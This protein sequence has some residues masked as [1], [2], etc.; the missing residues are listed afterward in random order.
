MISQNGVPLMTGAG[1]AAAR[2]RIEREFAVVH[3]ELSRAFA[4][5]ELELDEKIVDAELGQ[6]AF[7][8]ED[9]AVAETVEL[10]EIDENATFESTLLRCEQSTSTPVG[11]GSELYT[12][13]VEPVY[14]T[15]QQLFEAALSAMGDA[16]EETLDG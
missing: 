14:E 4:E 15:A 6:I 2:E 11:G 9:I 7:T 12:F 16:G 5:I 1:V 3:G 13:V 10:V 8:D